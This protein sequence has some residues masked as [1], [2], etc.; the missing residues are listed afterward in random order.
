M[1][2]TKSMPILAA[3]FGFLLAW[4]LKPG[5]PGAA[6]VNAAGNADA[7]GKITR[8]ANSNDQR[9]P[10]A[11]GKFDEN[12]QTPDG[13]PLPPELIAARAAIADNSRNSFVIKDQG[14]VQRLAELLNL[15]LDQQ[16]VYL[17]LFEQKRAAFNIFAPGIGISREKILEQAEAAETKFN[18]SLSKLLSSEQIDQ[19]NA[20]RKQQAVNR[21]LA[22]AQK[23]YADVLEKIDITPEQQEAVLNALRDNVSGSAAKLVDKTGLFAETYDIMGLG[24]LGNEMSNLAAANA[25][26]LLAGNQSEIMNT[27]I[28]N[29][30]KVSVEKIE[31]LRP[32]LTPAQLE[33]YNSI[34]QA[35]DESFFASLAPHLQAPVPAGLNEK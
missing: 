28:E 20:F 31:R 4:F 7:G 2:P 23:E 33:Q 19:L 26:V 3:I 30:K 27:L 35:R 9:P 11:S 10:S 6:A 22:G 21:A 8:S 18:N 17:G 14:Y 15:S 32:H 12:T 29:R 5:S 16:Q 1:L 13:K 25:A 34:L 24:E